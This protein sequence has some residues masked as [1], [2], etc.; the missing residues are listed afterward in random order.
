VREAA[1]ASLVLIAVAIGGATAA[2]AALRVPGTALRFGAPIGSLDTTF[3]AGPAAADTL[4]QSRRGPVI[5]FGVHATVTLSF[6]EGRLAE[7]AFEADSTSP[8]TRAYIED[9]LAREGYRRRCTRWD[10][11][12][13]VCD[14]SGRAE[15]HLD[16]SPRSLRATM[17]EATPAPV[18]AVPALPAPART[19][20]PERTGPMTAR[21]MEALARRAAQPP[22]PTPKPSGAGAPRNIAAARETVEADLPVDEITA[23]THGADG[24]PV[25]VDS[26]DAIRPEA[27]RRAGIFGT[28]FVRI[29][30]DSTGLV[31]G[32]AVTRGIPELNRAALACARRYRFA[33]PLRAGRPYA[34]DRVVSIRFT[35]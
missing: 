11:D 19:V 33:P 21:D 26:C 24:D 35:K 29:Q 27:A 34:F 15:I 25:L 9:E 13:H 3:A 6:R 4:I 23:M 17:K 31:S 14:W 1:A 18:A 12:A 7:A 5:W 30:V 16:L 2:G 8:A 22:T 32:A 20:A 28:V 10:P